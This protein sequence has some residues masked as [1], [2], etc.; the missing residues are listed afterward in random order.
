MVFLATRPHVI[1]QKV[2]RNCFKILQ[3]GLSKTKTGVYSQYCLR[4]DIRSTCHKDQEIPIRLKGI[5]GLARRME[6]GTT[7]E[8]DS[9]PRYCE[10][11][12]PGALSKFLLG[13][14][15]KCLKLY[16]CPPCTHSIHRHDPGRLINRFACMTLKKLDEM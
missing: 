3:K 2:L 4:Y 10:P 13:K 1:S 5:V 11:G 14:D 12:L 9:L 6:R 8:I 15:C 16:H 7:V